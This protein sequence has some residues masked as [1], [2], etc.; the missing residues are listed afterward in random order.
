MICGMGL[1]Y[2]E[3]K[4]N[5]PG[6]QLEE[7]EFQNHVNFEHCVVLTSQLR[8]EKPYGFEYSSFLGC[9]YL[10]VGRLLP[11]GH[12]ECLS[13]DIRAIS[14]FETS[15]NITVDMANYL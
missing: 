8:R 2:G 5:A 7:N 9:C 4:L 3:D 14:S 13:M 15:V 10:R 11:K 1:Q 6:S 12:M